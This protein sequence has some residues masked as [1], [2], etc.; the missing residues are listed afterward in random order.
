MSKRD[1]SATGELKQLPLG[2]PA[3]AAPKV[4]APAE[5]TGGV[6][7]T[8]TQMAAWQA[9]SPLLSVQRLY[10]CMIDRWDEC[11][12]CLAEVEWKLPVP[13]GSKLAPV[14]IGTKLRVKVLYGGPE[15]EIENADALRLVTAA[16]R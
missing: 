4:G 15:L 6:T 5:P 1:S 16:T 3:T 10:V 9:G 12:P 8:A 13:R 2:L 11:V 14:Q 7:P